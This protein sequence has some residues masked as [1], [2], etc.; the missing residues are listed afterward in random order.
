MNKTNIL[1]SIL[2]LGSLMLFL[3]FYSEQEFN[4]P[5][6]PDSKGNNYDISSVKVYQDKVRLFD[7]KYNQPTDMVLNNE[8]MRKN[9]GRIEHVRLTSHH[10]DTQLI[11]NFYIQSGKTVEEVKV[12]CPGTNCYAE[13]V[14]EG[15]ICD[16][17]ED[18][19]CLFGEDT[20]SWKGFDFVVKEVVQQQTQLKIVT[21]K[22]HETFYIQLKY[23]IR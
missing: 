6:I 1:V 16:L 15:V 9:I 4:L 2:L 23:N 3:F 5:H 11:R 14:F 21:K 20:I 17:I 19:E 12:I 22:K 18:Q 10:K 13:I 8:V 7:K